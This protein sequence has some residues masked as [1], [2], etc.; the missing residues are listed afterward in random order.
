MKKIIAVLLSMIMAFGIF[1]VSVSAQ[2]EEIYTDYPVI[3][4]PGYISAVLYRTDET[5]GERIIVWDD[6]VEQVSEGGDLASVLPDAKTYLTEGNVEPLAERLSE[7]FNRIFAEAKCNPDGTSLYDIRTWLDTAEDGNYAALKEKYPDGKHQYEK[8]MMDALGEKIGDE[9]L[10]IFTGDFRMG[11]IELAEDLRGFI[12]DVIAH[13][14]G[15]RAEKGKAPIDRV[16][17]FA[18]SHGGQV[19]GTYLALYG[20]EG[21][22]NNAVLT[23]PALG[24]AGIAYDVFNTEVSFDEVG[25]LTFIQHG[26]MLDEDLEILLMAQQLGFIDELVEALFPRVAEIIGYWGSLWDFIPLEQYEAVKAKLL[27]EE[28]NAGLIEKSDRMHYEIMSRDGE[29]SYEKGFAEAQATGT[30]IYIISGYDNEIIT[31]MQ[32]SSD[33]ILPTAD[34]T[35]ATVAPL[36]QRFAD[37]YTQKVDTGL[38]QVSPS[39]TLDASTS[40]LPEHTWFVENYYHGMTAKDDFTYSLMEKLLLTDEAFDV[41][42]MAEYPQFHATTNPAHSVWAAFNRSQEGYL[43]SQDTALVIRN[44]SA[45]RKMIVTAVTVEGAEIN[46]DFEPFTLEAGESREIPVVGNIP[47]VSLKNF[48]INVSYFFESFTPIGGRAFDFTLMNGE[49]VAYD[50]STPYVAA[51]ADFGSDI[52]FD[53]GVKNLLT[54]NF[55]ENLLSFIYDIVV[56]LIGL[57]M[58]AFN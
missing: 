2:Q 48:E 36:G 35:G 50:E 20:H 3:L 16:N 43:S 18:V 6:P 17:L 54:K 8:E 34:S 51:D 52:V 24:G 37:G 22:I 4:V 57:I 29:N 58:N 13:N 41:T 46:L 33:A 10:Y 11:A 9:N 55:V 44:L 23:C 45:E 49:A 12:D 1:T 30:N 15:I 27:D 28:V 40:Y 5:T 38:Y 7:G 19:S 53:E 26:F 56:K 42:S 31:G 32:V 14:N 47:A 25:L 21:K 39:M